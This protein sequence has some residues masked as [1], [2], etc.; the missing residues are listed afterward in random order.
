M[1]VSGFQRAWTSRKKVIENSPLLALSLKGLKS[2]N[3]NK[4][5]LLSK[6]AIF[7]YDF[8]FEYLK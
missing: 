8:G 6:M 1:R 7:D 3:L 2:E 4:K 5:Y